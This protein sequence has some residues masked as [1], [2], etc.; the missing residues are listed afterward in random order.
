MQFTFFKVSVQSLYNLEIHGIIELHVIIIR[1]Y[2]SL[3]RRTLG[4]LMLM[5]FLPHLSLI[6]RGLATDLSAHDLQYLLVQLDD[7]I[8]VIYACGSSRASVFLFL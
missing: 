5:I 3:N 4:Y 7:N 1:L 2:L 6:T 8:S